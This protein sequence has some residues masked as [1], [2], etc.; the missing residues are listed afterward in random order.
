MGVFV[1]FRAPLRVAEE[2]G[3]YFMVPNTVRY[4]LSI[5]EKN[6]VERWSLILSFQGLMAPFDPSL[7]VRK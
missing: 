7:E 4:L 3:S 5:F 1:R 2:L 6:E